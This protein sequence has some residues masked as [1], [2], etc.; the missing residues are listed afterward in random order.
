MEIRSELSDQALLAE[1]GRRLQTQRLDRNLTQDELAAEAGVSRDTVAR[2]ER[3]QSVSLSHAL[4]ILR[5]LALL[6]GL[7]ALI[8]EPLPSPLEQLERAG[9]RRRRAAGSHATQRNEEP[10]GGWSWGTR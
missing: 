4:R 2:L 5:A 6:E 8:P 1:I 7:A 10:G 9:R 3:G